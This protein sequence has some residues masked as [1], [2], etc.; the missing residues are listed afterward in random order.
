VAHRRWC[1]V[2]GRGGFVS[3]VGCSLS[4]CRLPVFC[5]F[6]IKRFCSACVGT[7]TAF[8]TLGVVNWPFTQ[9]ALSTFYERK[10]KIVS[11]TTHLE[12]SSR[13]RAPPGL[14]LSLCQ[15]L[16]VPPPSDAGGCPCLMSLIDTT[17]DTAQ[18]EQIQSQSVKMNRVRVSLPSTDT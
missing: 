15:T 11:H 8:H 1:G 16:D 17:R 14:A 18:D 2:K 3:F 13:S 10:Y 4:V 5:F 7:R 12:F 6:F 9:L